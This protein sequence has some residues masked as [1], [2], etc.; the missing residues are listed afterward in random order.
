MKPERELSQ[1]V[2][3]CGEDGRLNPEAVGFSRRPIVTCNLRGSWPRKKRWDYWCVTTDSHLVALTYADVDYLGLGDLWFFEYKTER[4]YHHPIVVPL[5]RGFSQSPLVNRA[6]IELDALG[7]RLTFRDEPGGTRL[8]FRSRPWGRSRLEGELFV[9]LPE[10]HETLNVVVPWDER[11]FQFTS[12]H[13]CRP[14]TGELTLDGREFRFAEDNEAFG[15]LDYGRGIWPYE[16]TWN[17]ASASGVQGGRVVGFNL[18]GKWTDGTGS[19]E[20]G[21]VL[22]GRL[23]KIS[24][25][26]TL[27]YDTRCFTDPWRLHTRSGSVDLRFVPFYDRKNRLELGVL[28]SHVHQCFGRFEGTLRAGDETVEVSEL[29]G[30]AEE[31]RA[32]W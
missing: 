28:R 24:E 2:R 21:V 19:T 31:H 32:R 30:W 1:P 3:L 27:E 13:Q 29:V 7:L 25:E 26:L 6:D 5:A 17:W 12:K 23:H 18:G 16:T 8:A 20:N 4:S 10:S 22:D 9:A 14:A 11:R 15:C